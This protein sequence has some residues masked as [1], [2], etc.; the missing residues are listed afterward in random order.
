TTTNHVK[1]TNNRTL[2]Q[3]SSS[4]TTKT[5]TLSMSTTQSKNSTTKVLEFNKHNRN[6]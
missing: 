2:P 6:T 3:R 5:K 4:S 1:S